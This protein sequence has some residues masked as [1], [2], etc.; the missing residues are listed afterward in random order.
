M[1]EFGHS[2]AETRKYEKT[3]RKNVFARHTRNVARDTIRQGPLT[4]YS[5]SMR[6]QEVDEVLAGTTGTM[7]ADRFGKLSFP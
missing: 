1:E 4:F 3:G 5:A 7:M 6:T 2:Q